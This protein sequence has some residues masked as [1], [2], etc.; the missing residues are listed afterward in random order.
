MINFLTDPHVVEAVIYV[1]AGLGLGL[2][3]SYWTGT[4]KRRW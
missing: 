3:L 2:E 4:Q 1:L